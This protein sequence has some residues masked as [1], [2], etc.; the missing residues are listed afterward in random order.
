MSTS[1]T[2]LHSGAVLTTCYDKDVGY[3]HVNIDDCYAEKNRSASGD[4]VA[5]SLSAARCLHVILRLLLTARHRS[6][7]FWNEQPHRSNPQPRP[8][9]CLG[10]VFVPGLLTF[11]SSKAGI[12][13]TAACLREATT[14]ILRSFCAVWRFRLVHM[15]P[16]PRLVPE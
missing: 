14:D 3:T 11:H 4:I 16:L 13:S 1:R 2:I 5:G 9:S 12:V 8:V 7:R 10:S 15:R 6:L